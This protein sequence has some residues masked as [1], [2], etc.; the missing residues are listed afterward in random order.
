MIVDS[1]AVVSVILQQDGHARLGEALDASRRVS[2]GAPTL[3]E[4][5]IV[6]IRRYDRAG[7]SAADVL[8]VP[9]A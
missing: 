6:L 4:T 8:R 9:A 3:F 5:E 7:S 2:I 1:S